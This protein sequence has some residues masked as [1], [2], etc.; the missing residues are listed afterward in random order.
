MHKLCV[1]LRR[2]IDKESL[3]TTG[4]KRSSALAKFGLNDN[5]VIDFSLRSKSIFINRSVVILNNTIS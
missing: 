3:M 2:S 5:N 4:A 1:F